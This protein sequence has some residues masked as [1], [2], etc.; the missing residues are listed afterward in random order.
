MVLSLSLSLSQVFSAFSELSSGLII[1]EERKAE[2]QQPP[3][4]PCRAA[5]RGRRRGP[6]FGSPHAHE[7]LGRTHGSDH[8]GQRRRRWRRRS[9]G[10]L[11]PR[12]HAR[13]GAALTRARGVQ[14]LRVR[15]SALLAGGHG[16]R[17]RQAHQP[18]RAI[19]TASNGMART[20]ASLEYTTSSSHFPS[21]S[22]NTSRVF[23]SGSTSHAKRTPSRA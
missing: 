23:G 2:E 1:D 22:R 14:A 4:A 9:G 18:A 10:R 5:P 8:G 19:S 11:A 17:A 12:R 6:T 21:T 3:V 7:D 16:P 20:T 13:H 15:R